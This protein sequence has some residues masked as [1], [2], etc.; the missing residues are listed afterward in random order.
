[1]TNVVITIVGT[2]RDA[3]GEVDSIEMM[4]AGRWYDKNGVR[5][6]IYEDTNISGLEGTKT[7]L[8]LEADQ[9]SL[10]RMGEVEYRQEFCLGKK[11]ISPYATPYGTM[12][13]SI[14]T[15][16]LDISLE[17]AG[18]SIYVVY[19]LEINGQWQSANT[20]SVKV[21]EESKRGY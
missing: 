8:K 3:G 20:L 4:T 11:S 12:Q 16:Q 19:D 6:I 15:R 18:G 13:M 2:Q 21:R 5:Y 17:A 10:V 1:M 9:V 14:E 7:M